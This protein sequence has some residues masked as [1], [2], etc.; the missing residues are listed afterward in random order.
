MIATQTKVDISSVKIPNELND[1][2]FKRTKPEKKS[3]GEIFS[4]NKKVG[5][6]FENLILERVH[7]PCT[8]SP[9]YQGIACVMVQVDLQKVMKND[10]PHI[11]SSN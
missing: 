4:D 9:L 7:R 8:S 3:S 1:E 5:I 10:I 11:T 6:E 2:Y